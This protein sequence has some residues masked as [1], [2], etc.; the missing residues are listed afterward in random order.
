MEEN[1]KK[2]FDPEVIEK[3]IKNYEV[4]FK[5]DED[6]RV[7]SCPKCNNTKFSA[8][9][10]YCRICGTY[11]YNICTEEENHKCPANAR[12]CEICGAHTKY[13]KKGF[14]NSYDNKT[15]EETIEQANSNNSLYSKT[16]VQP[17]ED[18]GLPF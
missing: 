3:N 12:F 5:L 10:E 4:D 17:L 11:I 18:D 8:N 7:L 6:M 2:E 14:F 9:A 15:Y 1:N 13:F 16:I